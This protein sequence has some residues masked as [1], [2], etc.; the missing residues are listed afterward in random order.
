MPAICSADTLTIDRVKFA[1]PA[2]TYHIRDPL[3]ETFSWTDFDVF[4][5]EGLTD[6]GPFTWEVTESD[7]VTQLDSSVYSVGDLTAATKT[8]DIQ[9][10]DIMKAG[11][12][13]F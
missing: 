4:S 10:D 12:H 9:T 1:D 8:I 3:G 13:S 7:G 5:A 11:L 2:A 6:C